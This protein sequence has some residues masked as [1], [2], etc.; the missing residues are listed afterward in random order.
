MIIYKT[1][2]E[3]ALM[4]EGGKILA[5]VLKKITAIVKP[6]VTTGQL[7]LLAC[8]LIA[9]AG[10]Y[11]SFKGYASLSDDTP[12]PTALCTSINSE[13]V[14][15]PSIPSRK[16]ESGDIIGIDIGMEYPYKEGGKRGMMTD[17]A[18]TVGVGK[19]NSEAKKL[20]SVTSKALELAIKQVKPGCKV[21]DIGNAIQTYV[22]ANGFSVV[23]D[24]VGHGV[25]REVHEDPQIFHYRINQ[26]SPENI[27]IKPGMTFAIEPMVNVGGWRVK[28][29]D[30]GF[31]FSTVDG[32]LSAQFEHTL[33]VT[34][35]GCEIIT[36]L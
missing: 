2:E 27:T 13:V 9:K 29:E 20:L 7:E 1:P 28:F 14:H 18:V 19:I 12:Y 8:D 36:K 4:R 6:G 11:P 3:I 22:E 33:A 21:N 35:K 16:L 17:M 10:G 32:S 23:R 5:G 34:E 30:D 26:N 15:A 25:G 31:T 24:L